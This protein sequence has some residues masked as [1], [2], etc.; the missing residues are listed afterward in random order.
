[1]EDVGFDFSI[2][3]EFRA[4]LIEGQAEQR[5]FEKLVE[6]IQGMGWIKER[7]KLRSESI[8]MLVK[9]MRLSR[10][11]MVVETLRLATVAPVEIHGE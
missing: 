6:G 4:R 10:I 3:N 7:G 8:A 5:V 9:V 2:L 1:M 11:E